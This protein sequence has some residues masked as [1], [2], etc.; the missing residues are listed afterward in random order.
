MGYF[1]TSKC[2]VIPSTRTTD[3]TKNNRREY[4]D[5]EY[6]LNKYVV[7]EGKRPEVPFSKASLASVSACVNGELPDGSVRDI[8]LPHTS[9]TAH[10]RLCLH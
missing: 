9:L 10:D 4:V 8:H 5:P 7:Q 1:P 3:K 6:K 2:V